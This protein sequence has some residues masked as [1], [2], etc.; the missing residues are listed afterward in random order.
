MS[1]KIGLFTGSFDPITNGHLDLI[2]RGSQLF[3]TLYVGLFYNSH[4]TGFL[5]LARR[6]ALLEAVLAD[7]ENVRVISA[8]ASL[9][10]D[11]ARQY[12][13]THLLRG[14]RNGQDLEYEA[15]LDFYNR[16]LAP[17]LDTVYLLA[18][19]QLKY[20][21]SSQIR[22]LIHFKADISSYVPP[23]ILEELTVNDEN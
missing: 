2:A 3:D 13:V 22:E 8:S 19:P 23:Q 11:V 10:V 12:G 17:T 9:V 1:D 6:K 4:K 7:F 5:P 14:L 21:S 20:V 15:S 18:Q 16:E